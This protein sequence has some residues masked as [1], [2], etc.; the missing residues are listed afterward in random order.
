M[1]PLTFLLIFS[2]ILTLI[3][4]LLSLG[5]IDLLGASIGNELSCKAFKNIMYQPYET[6][7]SQNSAEIITWV[8]SYTD[9]AVKAI[10]YAVNGFQLYCFNKRNIWSYKNR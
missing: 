3:I 6:H 1:I 4:R 2:V 7:L 10:K 8:V 5:I 9:S